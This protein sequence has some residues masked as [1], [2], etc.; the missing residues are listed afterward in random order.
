MAAI[1]YILSTLTCGLCAFLLFRQFIRARIRLLMW[2]ALCF[3][4]LT[5]NN[6]LLVIDFLLVPD[7]DL[8]MLR[9]IVADMSIAILALGLTWDSR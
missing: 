1:V 2:I 9:L 7:S 3:T 5:V 6:L 4:G 8:S